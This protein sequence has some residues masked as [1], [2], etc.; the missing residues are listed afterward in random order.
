M[1]AEERPQG[2][3]SGGRPRAMVLAQDRA[4]EKFAG[5]ARAHRP[6][7]GD[8]AAIEQEIASRVKVA[9]QIRPQPAIGVSPY[10]R[11]PLLYS[12]FVPKLSGLCRRRCHVPGL[13][14]AAAGE[15][16]V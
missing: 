7:V 6:L 16:L 2:E 11:N 9:C 5:A 10:Y 12:C 4:R 15:P 3:L 14:C 13:P 8:G 1:A